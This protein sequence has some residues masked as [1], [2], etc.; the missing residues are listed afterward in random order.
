MGRY[1]LGDDPAKT[2][3]ALGYLAQGAPEALAAWSLIQ[4]GFSGNNAK[5][6]LVEFVRAL[7]TLEEEVAEHVL[8]AGIPTVEA[9]LLERIEELGEAHRLKLLGRKTKT[10]A[11]AIRKKGLIGLAPEEVQRRWASS[12]S[13]ADRRAVILDLR[14]PN[15]IAAE[16]LESEDPAQVLGFEGHTAYGRE[17]LD[18]AV[19][20]FGYDWVIEKICKQPST[21]ALTALLRGGW[22]NPATLRKVAEVWSALVA[23]GLRAALDG[24]DKNLQERSRLMNVA[25]RDDVVLAL[26]KH[27]PTAPD[28][29]ESILHTKSLSR[30]A[31]YKMDRSQLRELFGPVADGAVVEHCRLEDAVAAEDLSRRERVLSEGS[32]EELLEIF[33]ERPFAAEEIEV[34][35][36]REK[37]PTNTSVSFNVRDLDARLIEAYAETRGL[38]E[39]FRVRY[40]MEGPMR[41]WRLLKLEAACSLAETAQIL[42]FGDVLYLRP[43]GEIAEYLAEHRVRL[44]EMLDLYS[45]Q[46]E[47]SFAQLCAILG[48]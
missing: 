26:A 5:R 44:G 41:K 16:A 42:P 29:I 32:F 25:Y 12:E 2:G 21:S 24:E 28:L 23:Q 38:G 13:L 3:K 37:R 48:E 40:A 47:L 20:R 6:A 19:A 8:K 45:A 7:P 36:K 4:D 43:P 35:T 39:Y 17:L 18:R 10:V 22:D 1:R 31:I 11:E 14:A 34:L 46:P 15:E 30:N 33:G 9:V 27:W